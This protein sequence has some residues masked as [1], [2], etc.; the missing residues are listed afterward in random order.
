MKYIIISL[1]VATTAG[2]GSVD[3]ITIGTRHT[4]VRV[5]SEKHERCEYR[6]KRD[7]RRKKEE[8]RVKCRKD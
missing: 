6:E 2:C 7:D 1:L 4:Q 8:R 5:D 3:Y